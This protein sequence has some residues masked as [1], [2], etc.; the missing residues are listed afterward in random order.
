VLRDFKFSSV[1][2]LESGRR[3][4]VFAGSDANRDGNPTS[5]RPGILGRNT[6]QGPGY[7][8][9]DLRVAREVA[10]KEH[11][12]GE[13]SLDF[14]NLLN[15]VNI[16]DLNTLYGGTDLSLPPNRSWDLGLREM[17]SIPDSFSSDSNCGS[18]G[19]AFR[20]QKDTGPHLVALVFRNGGFV[21]RWHLLKRNGSS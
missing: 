20:E 7:A 4:N 2:S 17:R 14:F 18:E 16:K 19:G 5:D 10:F 11:L 6:F 3:F 8:S 15:R 21:N 12:K 1:V 13:F 9:L